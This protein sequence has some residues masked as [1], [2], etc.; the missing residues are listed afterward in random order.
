MVQFYG[1]F[2][3]GTILCQFQK[4]LILEPYLIRLPKFYRNYICKLRC[5][6]VKFPVETGR[7]VGKLR[8]ERTCHLC[9][10]GSVADEFHYLFICSNENVLKLRD[11]YIP[12]YYINYANV[13]KLYG[14]LSNCNTPVLRK[15]AVFIQKMM[16]IL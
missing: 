13:F 2:V 5:A 16:K 3:K 10:D 12:A 7:W 15:L 9:M 1:K 11:K 4:E 14:L 6:N 8:E